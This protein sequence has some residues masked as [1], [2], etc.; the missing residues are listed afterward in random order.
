MAGEPQRP[1]R[2]A[3]TDN[4]APFTILGPDKQAYGLFVDMWKLWSVTTGIPVEFQAS[5]W[6]ETIEAVKNGTADVHSG[7]NKTKQREAFLEF[8][9]PIHVG[10]SALYFRSGD[11]QPIPFEDLAGEKVGVVEGTLHD[12]FIQDKYPNVIRVPFAGNDKLVSALLR[13]EVRA[14][15]DE[16]VANQATLARLGLSGVFQR[17]HETILTN[18][19]Y[20]G[21][22]KGNTALLEKINAGFKAI[23]RAKLKAAE[24]RWLADDFDHFYKAELGDSSNALNSTPQDETS[25]S[26]VLNDK[27]KLW[28]RQNPISRIAVMN[29]WPPYDFTDEEG[30]H[31]GMHSDLLRLINKHLGTNLIV[32]PFD[33]WP[34]AYTKAASGEVD[35]ILGLSWTKEREKT[36]L[37]SSAYYYEPASVLMR[38]GDTPI[39]E[40]KGLNGKTILVPKNTSII[41][42]IKAELPDAIVVEMLSKDDALTRLANGEGDAYVAWLSASPQ[43]LKDLKLAITAKIDDRQGEV[44]LGVPV[45][46]PVLASIV[47][48]GI[49]SITQS[50]WAALRE[51]WVPKAAG[52]T[53]LANLTNEEIQWIKDHKNVTFANEMDWPPFDFVEH[54]MPK[55]ISIELVDLIAQKTGI[56]VKF[57]N[58]YSW[59]E[60][61]EQFNN[62]DID[63]LPALYWTEERAKTF[64]FTTPY[65]VNSSVL[66]VHNDHKKL[67]SFA[68]LKGHKVG[69]IKGFGTAELLSQRYPEIELVTVTNALEG[70][71]KVSLG[72]IDAYF[73]SIG[74]ISHVL[75][76][77]LVPDLVLSFNHEMKNSTETQLHMAT[78][79]S[80]KL[81]RN[82]LQ[83]GL[84]AVSPEEMRTIRNRWLPLGSSE[85]RSVNERVVFSNEEKAF[86]AAHP[87]LKLGVDMAWPPFEFVEDGIHK[88]IS[89]DVVKKISEFSGIE[90]I[91]QTDLTW[92]QVLAGTKSGSIDIM[93]MMQPTAE[94]EEFLDFTKPYV[95]YPIVILTRDDTPFISS[96][97]A[98]GS[99][100][101]G[102]VSGYSIETMVKKHYQEIKRVPQTDLESMLRNLSS[103]KIDV[104][105]SNLAVATYAMNKLNLVNLRVTAPTE[106]NNDLAMG[107][108]KGNPVLL[109]I[110]QKSLD[111]ITESEMNAIKNSWV[112][113][114]VEFG[115]DLKTMMI[116]ALPVLGGFI[117]IVGFVV[118]WNRK[119]G[120]EVEERHEAERHSRMLLESVGEGIFGVDQ[121]GQ[122]TFVNSVASEALGYAPHELIGE[123]VHA[124]IHHTRPD[125]SDFPVKE[126]PMWEAYTKGKVS[127]IDN[128]ILWRKDGTSFPVEYNATPLRRHDSI[129][130]AVISFRDITKVQKATAA[131]HEHLEDVEKFNELAVDRELRMIE[132]KQE[133]NVLLKEKG[134]QEKYEIVQ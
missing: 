22:A 23:A 119:L 26:V 127:R 7:L 106:Y 57:V 63:V 44:T 79:K 107:V 120:R 100:K 109:S 46:K 4:Y 64:D 54:D 74:V 78:L 117:V 105:L 90:F 37:F 92:A 95:S 69:I 123:K 14:I 43:R 29:N 131:L 1:L 25:Q 20:V 111:A 36:F 16:T 17:G 15:F 18:F 27:E 24:S 77:N 11:T 34:E 51:Q 122:V 55:G 30:R 125:G 12:Q 115:L 110:L 83:K 62:G 112:A 56:N 10:R 129:I 66:V 116:Y 91:A 48:K 85:S 41:D 5:S 97:G 98:I 58:G 2:I 21:V 104:A 128:E 70:L 67:N 13:S 52:D 8:S 87:K 80:N 108:P 61:L 60:L 68:A 28:L 93:P 96:L 31:Y 102:M 86:I 130:G 99:L 103:G 101:T 32:L 45:S 118:V 72:T 9:D 84:D 49:N 133:I 81:L 42:K 6:S 126:C 33:A 53:N 3:I 59:A 114:Q 134:A 40:W 47:Q 38:V 35:G 113:L 76:N 65:A 89:A 73:D 50:E 75:D 94:R 132:L 82:I 121:I 39:K 124:L 19:V 71:Q 88:G